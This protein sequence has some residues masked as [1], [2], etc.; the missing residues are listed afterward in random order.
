VLDNLVALCVDVDNEV[1]YLELKL[2]GADVHHIIDSV[3]LI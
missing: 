1:Q 3:D 2:F